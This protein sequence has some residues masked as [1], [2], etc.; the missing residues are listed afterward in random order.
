MNGYSMTSSCVA[1]RMRTLAFERPC[2][3]V[4]NSFV[5][6][7][8]DLEGLREDL[9]GTFY[10]GLLQS[11]FQRKIVKW[12]EL[13]SNNSEKSGKHAVMNLIMQSQFF[14][15]DSVAMLLEFSCRNFRSFKGEVRL[16][17]LLVNAYKSTPKISHPF[18]LLVPGRTE[19]SALLPFIA[20]TRLGRRIFSRQSFLQRASFWVEASPRFTRL[21]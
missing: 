12:R 15:S 10:V 6:L 9:L 16:T 4:S 1:V 5:I 19:C 2:C 7:P 8:T 18:A 11:G 14:L 17:L 13:S 20:P 21:S 3:F